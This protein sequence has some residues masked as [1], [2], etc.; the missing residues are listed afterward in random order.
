M[1]SSR[2]GPLFLTAFPN[3]STVSLPP[4]FPHWRR[5]RVVWEGMRPRNKLKHILQAVR[6]L[7]L[8]KVIYIERH[9]LEPD[10]HYRWVLLNSPKNDVY[11]FG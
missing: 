4:F 3:L 7:A 8:A 10:F 6:L 2:Q 1:P 9:A 5:S 11:F